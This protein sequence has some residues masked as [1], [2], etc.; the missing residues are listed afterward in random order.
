MVAYPAQPREAMDAI[1][2]CAQQAGCPLRVPEQEDL[3]IYKS[4]P[5]ENRVNYGGYDL[6]VPFPGRHQALNA[7]VVVEAALALDE[8]GRFSIPDEDVY[9]RQAHVWRARR[10]AGKSFSPPARAALALG[11]A[12]SLYI[13]YVNFYFGLAYFPS[14]LGVE[15]AVS[16]TH[17]DVYKRQTPPSAALRR[18]CTSV[19]ATM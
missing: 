6:A 7:A 1:T 17:L 15:E 8:S 13:L 12:A 10:D 2:L 9:K 3:H 16:Y 14:L 5:F 18:R 4:A 19:L 11:A